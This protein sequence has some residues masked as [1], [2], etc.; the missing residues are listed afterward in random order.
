MAASKNRV[1]ITILCSVGVMVVYS[2]FYPP[3]PIQ[4]DKY[5][6]CS[7]CNEW[8]QLPPAKSSGKQRFM[9]LVQNPEFSKFVD[10]HQKCPN[11]PENAGTPV[12]IFRSDIK[13][14]PQPPQKASR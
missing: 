11:K 12:I 10:K 9:E 13:R 5:A 4:T 8:L 3:Q 1:V 14:L 2:Y 7:R 6:V